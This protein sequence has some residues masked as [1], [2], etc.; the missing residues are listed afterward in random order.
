VTHVFL[1]LLRATK[2]PRIVNV[3]NRGRVVSAHPRARHG[4]ARGDV[5][6]QTI[7]EGTDAIVCLT[8]LPP[9]GPTSTF[10]GRHGPV[11]W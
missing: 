6:T 10:Q 2:H 8:I 11:P 4:G 3:P 5:G 9:D 1:P 7:T